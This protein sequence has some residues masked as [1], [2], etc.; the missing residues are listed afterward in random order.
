MTSKD[1]G[2]VT[3]YKWG[4][5]NIANLHGTAVTSRRRGRSR[6]KADA[7]SGSKSIDLAQVEASYQKLSAELAR[8]ARWKHRLSKED[9]KDIVQE[10]F[11]IAVVKMVSVR[12]ARAWLEGI[13]DR[14]AVNF[15]RTGERRAR[16]LKLWGPRP[17]DQQE[18]GEESGDEG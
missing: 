7:Y 10:A 9:A 2:V 3:L 8:R 1:L 16:L 5:F 18:E 13:V 17:E 4:I 14:L 11:S 6:S 15:R 12:N